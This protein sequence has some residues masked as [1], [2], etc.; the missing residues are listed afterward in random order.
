MPSTPGRPDG[1]PVVN[2]EGNI[3]KTQLRLFGVGQKVQVSSHDLVSSLQ[4]LGISG[5]RGPGGDFLRSDP[6]A[7][8][9]HQGGTILVSSAS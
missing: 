3:S 8:T 5:R 9:D 4:A 7:V 2:S 1:H 6:S